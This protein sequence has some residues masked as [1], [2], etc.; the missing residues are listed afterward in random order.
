MKGKMLKN[1]N[2]FYFLSSQAIS[3]LGDWI[4]WVPLLAFVYES[5]K[6]GNAIARVSIALTVTRIVFA[7][8]AGGYS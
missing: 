5:T 7:P 4:H 6:S 2:F 8:I 1:K 3:Q